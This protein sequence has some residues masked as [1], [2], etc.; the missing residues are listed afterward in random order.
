[1]SCP[2]WAGKIN[3][4]V[5]AVLGQ[6]V[7]TNPSYCLMTNWGLRL[8]LSAE[9]GEKIKALLRNDRKSLPMFVDVTESDSTIKIEEIKG[10][11]PADVI[12]ND[13]RRRRGDWQCPKTLVWHDK[14]ADC[15]C[16]RRIVN[17]ALGR[18]IGGP[19]GEMMTTE[20]AERLAEKSGNDLV[21]ALLEMRNGDDPWEAY[22]AIQS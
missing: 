5:M 22:K 12:L 1:M 11:Y 15:D 9:S 13:D 10:I 17:P 7:N 21:H 19:M 16:L 2:A 18:I 4:T 14:D 3:N 20:E 6:K 8:W